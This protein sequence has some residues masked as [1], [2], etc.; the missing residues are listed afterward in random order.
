VD[1]FRH[2]ALLYAGLDGFLEGTVPFLQDAAAAGDPTLVVVSAPKIARLRHELGPADAQRIVFA[3]MAHVGVNPARIIPA[4]HAFVDRYGGRGRPLRGIGEPIWA[5]RS[6]DEL[7]ECQ[8]HESLLNLAFFGAGNF[9]LMCP[10]DT[11]ALDAAVIEEA[12]RSHAVMWHDGHERPSDAFV[13]VATVSE[14]FAAPLPDPPA[15]AHAV[16]FSTGTLDVLRSFVLARAFQAGL[17]E[18][19]CTD[20]VLAVNELA[21]NSVRYAGGEGVL[22]MWQDDGALICEVADRGAILEPLAGR[23]RPTEGQIGGHGLWVV[24]QLCDLV[25]VRAFGVVRVHIRL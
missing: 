7:I 15:S 11:D 4:W 22:R 18:E 8:R 6:P 24:N 9:W 14:P 1:A 3:D 5:E 20:V 10:Y 19:R 12:Q 16:P 25:Q 21:T 2:D 13:D 23:R 17:T